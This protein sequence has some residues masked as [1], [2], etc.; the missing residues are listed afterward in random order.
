VIGPVEAEVFKK[1][2]SP[3]SLTLGH[4]EP[5]FRDHAPAQP[6]KILCQSKPTQA[7]LRRF[8]LTLGVQRHG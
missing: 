2:Q 4:R 1:D 5:H 6:Q 3:V 8:D 7:H